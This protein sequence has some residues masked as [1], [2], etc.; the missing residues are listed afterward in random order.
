MYGK[1]I[2]DEGSRFYLGAEVGSNNTGELQALGEALIW[3]RDHGKRDRV[4][5]VHV[6]SKYAI[7]GALGRSGG[8]TNLAMVD[9]IAE[10]CYQVLRDMH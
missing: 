1:V 3:I 2:T 8:K 6:D 9:T 10:L 4:Y 7:N 5:I